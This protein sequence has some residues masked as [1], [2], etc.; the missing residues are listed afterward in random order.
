MKAVYIEEYGDASKLIVGEL[1]KPQISADQVLI[2]VRSAAVNP[3]DW[4]VR[5]GLLKEMGLHQLPLVLGWDVAGEIVEKGENVARFELSDAVFAYA[6]IAGQGAYA[7]YIAI[8]SELVA[9]KPESLSLLESA[10]VPLAATTAWQALVKGCE[11]KAGDKVLIHN[12]AGGVG[13]FAVQIA[14]AKGAFVIA[15]ASAA[16]HDFVKSL[17]A[18]QVIDYRTERFEDIVSDL[19]AVLAAVGGDDIL[20]RSLKVIRKGG[21]LISLLDE[22]DEAQVTHLDINYQRWWVAPD[23]Q[24]LAEIA[25]LIDSKVI[26]VVVDKV[27]PLAQVAQAHALS[28]AKAA[29][30]KI[31]LDVSDTGFKT[32]ILGT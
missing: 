3:V 21:H 1:K 2:K 22:L 26:K 14:K 24:D 17:G 20:T 16:K 12:A 19:D 8:E 15:T 13:S 30:G 27:F 6:P 10:A 11:L 18:D 32:A 29:T 25:R 7:E 4:M 23:A 31:L 9:K 5:A 28:E